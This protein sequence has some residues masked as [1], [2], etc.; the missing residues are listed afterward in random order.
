VKLKATEEAAQLNK[1]LTRIAAEVDAEGIGEATGALGKRFRLDRAIIGAVGGDR[2]KASLDLALVDFRAGKRLARGSGTWE[3]EGD[4]LERETRALVRKLL[5]EA[6]EA[7]RQ[8]AGAGDPLDRGADTEAA[9]T[10]ESGSK[11]RTVE[12]VR[13]DEAPKKKARLEVP[14]KKASKS[15]DPLQDMTG[16]DD[17]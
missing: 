17:Y 8:I 7:A 9:A 5:S 15:K 12:A 1:V 10:A 6:H 11:P 3:T 13:E 4:T 2:G 14:E 16:I